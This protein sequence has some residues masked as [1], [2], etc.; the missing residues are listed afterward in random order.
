MMTMILVKNCE[1]T[2]ILLI[3]KELTLAISAASKAAAF[4]SLR[5]MAP[6]KSD[7]RGPSPATKAIKRR[8]WP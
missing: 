4:F 7:F 2:W 6:R 1:T 8:G 5:S 3:G